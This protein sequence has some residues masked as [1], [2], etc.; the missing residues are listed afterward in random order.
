MSGDIMKIIP[1]DDYPHTPSDNPL[2]REG[3]HFNGYD[4]VSRIGVTASIGIKP[5]QGY[6]EEIVAVHTENPVVFLT[7]R[8][9]DKDFLNVGTLKMEI[10][11]PLKKWRVEMKDTF[12]KMENGVPSGVTNVEL[13]LYFDSVIPPYKY[14]TKRGERYEQPGTLEGAV[15][16]GNTSIDFKGNGVRDH[17]WELRDMTTWAEWYSLLGW[18]NTDTYVFANF[19]RINNNILHEGWLKTDTYYQVDN[20]QVAPVF[21]DDVLKECTM[22]VQASGNQ[23]EFTSRVLSFFFIPLGGE[24]GTIV[25][26]AVK[27][28][29]DGYAFLWYGGK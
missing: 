21:S 13:D 3:Y 18:P 19:F 1:E 14:S 8:P 12:Q 15:K 6:R 28:G 5:F 7:M 24:Q 20:V 29:K 2:W 17:S 23:L 25:E 22:Q 27:L 16:V 11:E 4:P 10:I 9:L 26:T